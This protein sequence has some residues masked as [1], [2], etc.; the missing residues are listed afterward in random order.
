MLEAFRQLKL[1]KRGSGQTPRLLYSP[2]LIPSVLKR[3]FEL[4]AKSGTRG[5]H[6]D[7]DNLPSL[8]VCFTTYYEKGDI[9]LDQREPIFEQSRKVNRKYKIRK[10]TAIVM[11]PCNPTNNLWLTLADSSSFVNRAR[12]AAQQ[13]T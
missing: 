7:K 4:V 5:Q 8:F 11:D 6:Y 12:M 1:C 13:I 10:A 3:F 9:P 2:A